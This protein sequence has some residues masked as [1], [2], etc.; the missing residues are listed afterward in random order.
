[1]RGIANGII[2]TVV[3]VYLLYLAVMVARH[4]NAWPF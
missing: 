2:I 1:M 3:V 4:V